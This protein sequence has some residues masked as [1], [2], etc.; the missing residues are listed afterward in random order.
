MPFPLRLCGPPVGAGCG[1]DRNFGAVPASPDARRSGN[2][3]REPPCTLSQAPQDTSRH[4]SRR[5][6]SMSR[7]CELGR[8]PAC[9]RLT[10]EGFVGSK[11]TAPTKSS[12]LNGLFKNTD[13]RPG[14][15]GR[16]PPVHAFI[17]GKGAQRPRPHP[18]R[19]P[20]RAAPTAGTPALERHTVISSLVR[21]TCVISPLTD[22]G[23]HVLACS[24]DR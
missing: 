8:F 5:S 9:F 17:R 19:P 10:S 20:G 14:N 12:Q 15:R 21:L 24:S 6:T 16:E 18:L 1:G 2:H 3:L 22:I 23:P 7:H 4:G 11:P 13:R